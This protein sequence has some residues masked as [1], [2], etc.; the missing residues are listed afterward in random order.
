MDPVFYDFCDK[1]RAGRHDDS[2]DTM[3]DLL[4][5]RKTK[6]AKSIKPV[7]PTATRKNRWTGLPVTNDDIE[8]EMLVAKAQAQD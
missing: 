8:T 5:E 4:N 6:V 3:I 1:L 2:I 7:G